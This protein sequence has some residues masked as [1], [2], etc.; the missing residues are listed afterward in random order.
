MTSRTAS[1]SGEKDGISVLGARGS[2]LRRINGNLSFTVIIFLF[3]H[4]PYFLITPRMSAL[5][6]FTLDAGLLARSQY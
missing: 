1:E 2:I 3:K 6:S 4:S 5:L